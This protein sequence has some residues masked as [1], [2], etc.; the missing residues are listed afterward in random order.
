MCITSV[1][2][3]ELGNLKLQVLFLLGTKIFVSINAYVW[4]REYKYSRKA[5]LGGLW[6]G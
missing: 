3:I 1:G 5:R 4:I 2:E 6:A